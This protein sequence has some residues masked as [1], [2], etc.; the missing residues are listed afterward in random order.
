MRFRILFETH[1]V[2]HHA[3][4]LDLAPRNHL[5]ALDQGLGFRAAVRFHEA[6]HHVHAALAQAVRLFQHTVGLAH[7]SGKADVELESTA[8]A[9]LDQF[10]K[11]LGTRAKRARGHHCWARGGW[12]FILCNCRAICERGMQ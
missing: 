1:L 2:D 5:Q 3:P 6:H 11:V 10:Q 4:V 9:L 12:S 8:L 7:A